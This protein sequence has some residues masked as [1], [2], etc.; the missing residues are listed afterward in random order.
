MSS[1]RNTPAV[2]TQEPNQGPLFPHP[3]LQCFN[4]TV[5]PQ[6][7]T[8]TLDPQEE[9]RESREHSRKLPQNQIKEVRTLMSKQLSH[10]RSCQDVHMDPRYQKP[11]RYADIHQH[12]PV[13]QTPIEVSE[14]DPTIQQGVIQ[15]PV[16]RDTQAA[17]ARPRRAMSPMN[18]QQTV[19][20]PNLQVAEN[21]GA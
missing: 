4:L 21:G 8:N 2:N 7:V 19:S 6:I 14:I 16:H 12:R 13:P 18:T 11:Q 3:P 20:Q 5:I 15:R 10:Q 9:E 17:G 1:R